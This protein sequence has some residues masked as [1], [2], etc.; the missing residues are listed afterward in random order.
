M[1]FFAAV[2]DG[3]KKYAVFR[4]RTGRRQFWFFMLFFLLVRAAILALDITTGG[5]TVLLSFSW[6]FKLGVIL[7]CISLVWRRMH[8]I[9]RRGANFFF[10]F[11]PVIGWIYLLVLLCLKSR[12]ENNRYA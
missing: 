7:P 9:G 3:F 6:L 5:G 11:L 10:I 1:G 12:T 8:D 4:G 2:A